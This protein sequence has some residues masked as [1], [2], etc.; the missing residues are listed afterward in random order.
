MHVAGTVLLREPCQGHLPGA[1]RAYAQA[2]S[3]MLLRDVG[4]QRCNNSLHAMLHEVRL[5]RCMAE[6]Y[7]CGVGQSLQQLQA[8]GR[9]RRFQQCVRPCA[10]QRSQQTSGKG[11]LVFESPQPATLAWPVKQYAGGVGV[12]VFSGK[13]TEGHVT[14]Q[15]PALFCNHQLQGAGLYQ[16]L[17]ARLGPVDELLDPVQMRI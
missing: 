8:V 17:Q 2:L 3:D 5:D 4:R 9:L 11:R 15:L 16:A 7:R 1:V 10:M 6:R 14:V 12:V 13:G